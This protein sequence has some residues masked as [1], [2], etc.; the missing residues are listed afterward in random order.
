MRLLIA[1][2]TITLTAAGILTIGCLEDLA[3][4]TTC[5]PDPIVEAKSCLDVFQREE[6]GCISLQE[7]GLK[8]MEC[9]TGPRTS[10]DCLPDECPASEDACFPPA[11]CPEAVVAEAG[12][13]VTCP[14]LESA[15]FAPIEGLV[16]A[17][18]CV[19]GCFACAA[20]CDGK[21]P[22]FGTVDD[23][24]TPA[25]ASPI[26]GVADRLPD[27]GTLGLYLRARGFSNAAI[28]VVVGPIE[29][30]EGEMPEIVAGYYLSTAPDTFG[31]IVLTAQDNLLQATEGQAYTWKTPDRKPT[32]LVIVPPAPTE[33]PAAPVHSL[34]ELDCLVPFV[35]P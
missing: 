27:A 3:A 24:V 29:L 16:Q 33:L 11:D 13:H 35:T 5:P 2:A 6:I 8:A 9:L 22:V 10:C 1:A 28:Y 34:W 15:D 26:I 32:F 21:G 31:E 20:A 7:G 30:P 19:C 18:Q 25:F 4:P 23:G 12:R 17:S 14:R